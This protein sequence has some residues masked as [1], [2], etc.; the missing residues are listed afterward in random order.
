LFESNGCISCKRVDGLDD[1]LDKVEPYDLD[2]ESGQY[3][4]VAQPIRTKLA[5]NHDAIRDRMNRMP[6]SVLETDNI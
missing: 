3:F 2:E 1:N 6:E 5:F 4:K